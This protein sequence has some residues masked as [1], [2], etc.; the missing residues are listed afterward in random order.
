MVFKIPIKSR[1][2]VSVILG[3][4]ALGIVLLAGLIFQRSF[5]EWEEKSLDYRFRLRK[6]IPLYPYITT[7]GIE[8]SSLE[9]IGSWPWDRSYHARMV[10]L[11]KTLGVSFINF[12]LFFTAQSSDPGDSQLI[13]AVQESG[14][15]I[16]SAPFELIDHPC[17]PQKEYKEFLEK[18]PYAEEIIKSLK[19]QKN[20][21]ICVAFNELTN[22]QWN[23][24]MQ[25]GQEAGFE[26]L[27]HAE[28]AFTGE[29]DEKKLEVLLEAVAPSDL[30]VM[31]YTRP[32]ITTVWKTRSCANPL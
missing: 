12:D 20:D 7:I 23:K 11:L 21:K 1:Y 30:R 17:F 27:Y 8:D 14:N 3:L 13:N 32:K 6:E 19:T 26:L 2:I 9:K 25:E 29:K 24:L 18:Y 10:K 28:F 22:E 16:L 15:V 4:G 5:E 31:S